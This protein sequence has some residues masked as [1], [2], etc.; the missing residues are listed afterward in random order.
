M[1]E[2]IK[3][4]SD[5]GRPVLV[6]TTSVEKSER[7]SNQLARKYGIKHEVLNAKQ[8]EREANIVAVAGH[9][10]INAHGERVGNVTIATNMAGRGTDIK[11]A[12]EAWFDVV[13]DNGTWTLTQRG[14]NAKQTITA[15]SPLINAY[16]LTPT[17]TVCGGL[18]VIGTERHTSRRID[19][20]LR[21]RSGR[22]GDP[23][24]S[25]F[26]CSL[27]DDLLKMFMGEWTVN[28]F[29][30]IGM[31]YGEAIESKMLT[32]G[33]M[34]AQRKV[35]ERNFLARK[36]LLDYDEVMDKQR[37]TFYGLRQQVLEGRH[38]EHVIWDMIGQSI[39]DAVKKY[40][41]DDFVAANLAE[42]ARTNFEVI[43]DPEE[44]HGLRR[45]EDVESYIRN[46]AKLELNTTISQTIGEYL[47]ENPDDS[48][49]WDV[50]SIERM[51]EKV[52]HTKVPAG[53]I[54]KMSAQQLEDVLTAGMTAY[55]DTRDISG[56]QQFLEPDYAGRALSNWAAEKFGVTVTPAELM[57]D[58]ER[59]V[60]KPS[61]EIV[62]LIDQR[63]RQMYRQR[64]H[65]YPIDHLLGQVGG[66]E[67]DRIDNPYAADFVKTWA[68]FKYGY[69]MTLEHIQQTPL[70]ELRQ[71]L[72]AQQTKFLEQGQLE[73]DVNAVMAAGPDLEKVAEA[74]NTRFGQ[75]ATAKDLDPATAET[76]K[77]TKEIDE[78]Q[79]GT[80]TPR[81]II[82]RR[83]R[84]ILRGELTQLEQYVLI[85]I[86]DQAWKDHLYAM[87]VLKGSIGLQGFAEK[88]PKVAYKRDGY[89]YFEQ[90]LEGIRDK[91]TDLIFR[92]RVEGNA[93]QAR[94]AYQVT[95]AQH[96]VSD[97]YGVADNIAETAAAVGDAPAAG[98]EEGASVTKTIVRDQPKVGRN[99]PCPCG[100][101]KKY[102]NCHGANE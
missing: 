73:K 11:L 23:G 56:I 7:I 22:Q 79:S 57:L 49:H 90:M 86:F 74:F 68:H 46:Q 60:F 93:V 66:G 48:S 61:D 42:W 47:G 77:G 83:A 32:R 10:H 62:K 45:Y 78:D 1:I 98:E 26:Y 41:V 53:R 3:L 75:R 91:V 38:I 54:K 12:P 102:K 15:D 24:S 89:K 13:Y 97:A 59:H 33:I 80:V 96:Q 70:A 20:Q 14:T 18:H 34:K 101:G 85:T 25:R 95:S 63:A 5:A 55:I 19:N 31:E 51:A 17:T 44:L 37:S 84:D 27:Q 8:H 76:R 71:E 52:Y 6:G 28:V 2:E 50:K 88:D 30:K 58:A 82:L 9:T 43:I 35:E 92:V 40:V 69:E 87:D 36:N 4:Y 39:D 72:V 65:E 67:V 64:E 94:N 81:D 100:S 99:D 29:K 21:G 16:H